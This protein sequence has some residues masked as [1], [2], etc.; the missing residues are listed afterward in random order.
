LCLLWPQTGIPKLDHVDGSGR[1]G[2]GSAFV[3]GSAAYQP[4]TTDQDSE[5]SQCSNSLTC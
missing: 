1:F 5:V 2:I 4:Q 3:G